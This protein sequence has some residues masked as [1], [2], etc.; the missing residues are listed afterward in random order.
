MIINIEQVITQARAMLRLLDTQENIE[1]LQTLINTAA[2]YKLN[3]TNTYTIQC[4]EVDIEGCKQA[5]LPDNYTDLFCFILDGGCCN[6]CAHT[7][8]PEPHPPNFL[9]C[10]CPNVYYYDKHALIKNELCGWYENYFYI[11]NGYIFFPSKNTAT[12]IKIYYTGFNTDED[13]LMLIDEEQTLALANYAAW[14]YALS[15]PEAYTPE[16]RREW[17]QSWWGELAVLNGKKIIREFKLQKP[18]ISLLVNG[19]L[20]NH[21][22]GGFGR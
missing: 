20:V 11:Q 15:F 18:Q 19:L 22:K 10:S 21:R 7:A 6:G 17:K 1:F 8:L 4:A 9:Y 2:Q 12:S 16:Q 14:Q 3:A 5:K 13:G